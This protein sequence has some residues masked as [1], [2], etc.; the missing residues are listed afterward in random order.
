[1]MTKWQ[2]WCQNDDNDDKM[3]TKWREWWQND[4]RMNTKWWQ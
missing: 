1:M 4:D 2:G 3:I